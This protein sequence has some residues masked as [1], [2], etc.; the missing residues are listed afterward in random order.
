LL[1][2]KIGNSALS[3]FT[4]V[5]NLPFTLEFNLVPL[6]NDVHATVGQIYQKKKLRGHRTPSPTS[7]TPKIAF[8]KIAIT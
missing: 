5:H 6:R 2:S 1:G 3:V 7:G 8:A 4:K